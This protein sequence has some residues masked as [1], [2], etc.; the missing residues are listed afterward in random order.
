MECK[1][2]FSCAALFMIGHNRS[3]ANKAKAQG[4]KDFLKQS[5]PCHVGTH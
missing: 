4:C 2:F 5:K 1:A 3:N